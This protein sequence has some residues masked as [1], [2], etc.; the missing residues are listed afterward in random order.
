MLYALSGS[1][2][3]IGLTALVKLWFFLKKYLLSASIFNSWR[4]VKL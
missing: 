1:S 2:L 4:L 3:N